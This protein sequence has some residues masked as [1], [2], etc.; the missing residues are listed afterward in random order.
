MST[1]TPT[2]SDI[3]KEASKQAAK[4]AA[5]KVAK[6]ATKAVTTAL[7]WKV[8]LILIAALILILIPIVAV[9]T[10]GFISLLTSEPPSSE[11]GQIGGVKYAEYFNEAAAKYE[12]D[13]AW[14]AAIAHQESGF[15]PKVKS[16]AGALG[17]MQLMPFN[18][19][20]ID[21]HDPRENILRGAEI[22][23]GHLKKYQDPTLALAAY[24]A[25]PGAVAKYDGIPPYK[26]TQ[27]YVKAVTKHYETY[28]SLV[29]NGHIAT[30]GD[31][32]LGLPAKSKISCGFTCY[33]NHGGIDF[34]GRGDKS[35]FAAG[36]GRVVRKEDHKGQSYGTLVVID[37]GG[38]I[39][40]AYAHMYWKDIQVELGAMVKRGQK[41]GKM[42]NNGNSSGTHLHFE[43][44][45][46]GKRIDPTPYIQ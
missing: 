27:N 8:I 11:V 24:N 33:K 46:D 3:A 14:L 37:H 40:T 35:V 39:E 15:D 7:G 2:L 42:G 36:D 38:G 32:Q 19:K 30:L 12:V 16:H 1:Q 34:S 41:I 6:K 4:R 5:I 43:I 9:L 26:E 13:P 44:R 17:V 45:N 25:G 22:F 20:G 29:Q 21:P 18:A 28:K 23:A 10:I 31:G